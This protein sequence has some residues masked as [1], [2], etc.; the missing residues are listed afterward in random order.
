MV[1]L[2]N[3]S[4]DTG[5]V[6]DNQQN[7]LIGGA[8][9]LAALGLLYKRSSRD[10][11]KSPSSFQLSGGAVDAGEVKN[12][13]K[14]Y[15]GEYNTLERGKGAVMKE[16]QK[17]A[18]LVDKFYSLVTDLY[19]WGWGQSFHFA[20]KLPNRDWSASEV[21]H[22]AWAAATIRLGPGKTALD[23][24]CGV[25]G[26]MRTVAGV[27]GGNVVGITIN[28]YQVQRA[29]YHNEK[30]G[31]SGQCKAVRGNF[32]EMPFQAGA[33][34][35]AYA[36]EAT[37]H[38][39][40]LEQ[41]YSEVYRVL[42]PGSIFMTYEWV[43]TP[44]FDPSNTQHVACVDE[45][46]IGNGLPD[47]RTWKQ[48][49]EAGKA[50]GFNLLESR[51]VAQASAAAVQPWYMRL[52]GNV[53]LF[54]WIGAF[55]GSI[56]AVMEFLRI[57]PRGLSDVHKM[58]FDTGVSVMEGGIEGIFTP[59]HMLIFQKPADGESQQQQQGKDEE[60]KAAPPTY[61]AAAAAAPSASAKLANGKGGKST[62]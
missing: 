28:E 38:A 36:M 19:E 60:D 51:D 26:P 23:V 45:I 37:C 35:A 24:G 12:T 11:K 21:A 1:S 27:S 20:R 7:L 33:F 57:A 3:F 9:G 18:D 39:P 31:L 53:P 13:V 43:T 62:A 47:M 8:A 15:Y 54:R 16:S 49:E 58:L 4:L 30:Q 32:L 44:R 61:A 22:E 29:T 48:A 46:I 40:T 50:V 14:E 41:V 5:W 2:G 10:Y 34:D 6:A 56:V 55:N 17:V 42:K 59:M 52:G 25:G